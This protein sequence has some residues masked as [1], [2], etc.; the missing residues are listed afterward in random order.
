MRTPKQIELMRTCRTRATLF[1]AGEYSN[2]RR[3]VKEDVLRE[4]V[5][6]GCVYYELTDKGRGELDAIDSASVKSA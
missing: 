3:L 2:A 6:F 4:V 1:G 5:E